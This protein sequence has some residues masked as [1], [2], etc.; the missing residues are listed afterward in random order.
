M[1][2]SVVDVRIGQAVGTL[3]TEMGHGARRPETSGLLETRPGR[4]S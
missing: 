3:A 2:K 4:S 1:L